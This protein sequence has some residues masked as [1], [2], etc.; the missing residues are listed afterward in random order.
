[1]ATTTS[2]LAAAPAAPASLF[3]RKPFSTLLAVTGFAL[4]TLAGF[5]ILIMGLQAGDLAETGPF[6]LFF[7][8][9]GVLGIVLPWRFARWGA[10]LPI[11]LAL[12]LCAMILPFLWFALLHP[13]GGLEFVLAVLFFA[14]AALGIIGGVVST[15]RGFRRTARPGAGAWQRRAYGGGLGLLVGLIAASFIITALART[16]L[17]ADVRAGAREMQVKD[18][19]F[20]TRLLRVAAGETV[21]LAVRNDDTALHTFTLPEAGVDIVIPA[22]AERL[23]EFTAPAAGTYT[24]YCVPHTTITDAGPEGMV[25][26]LTVTP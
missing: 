13:E 23:V 24:W 6:V 5:V 3:N 18:F 12:A 20:T 15:I 17:A 1:M 14:G 9:P 8:V 22:G 4:L 11:G 25:G 19:N 21:R 26:T 16:S 2:P 10:I 7:L